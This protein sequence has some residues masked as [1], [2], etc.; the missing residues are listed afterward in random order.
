MLESFLELLDGIKI[1]IG[2]DGHHVLQ[3]IKDFRQHTRPLRRNSG[4]VLGGVCEI[5]E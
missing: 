4:I 1:G 5:R 2:E 3:N